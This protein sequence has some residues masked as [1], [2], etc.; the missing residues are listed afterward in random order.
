M[1]INDCQPLIDGMIEAVWIVDPLDLRIVA[2]NQAAEKLLGF[3]KEEQVGRPV[4]EL[5]VTPEDTCFWEDVAAGLSD[6]IL[7]ETLMR[8]ADGTVVQVERRASRVRTGQHSV[9]IVGIRDKTGERRIEDELETL[10]AELRATLESTADGIL[11]ATLDKAIRGYNHHFA[12]LWE[13]PDKL[14]TERDDAAVYDWM[15]RAVT[16][17]EGYQERL[18]VIARTPLLEATDIVVLRSGR[19]LERVTMPQY[20]RGRPIGRVFSFRDI[21]RRLA[22]ESRLQL[23]AKVFESSLDAIFISDSHYRIIAANPSCER[24]TGFARDEII[25]QNV[26]DL[27]YNSDSGDL[28]GA[29]EHTLGD[30]GVWEGEIWYRRKTG[31]ACPGLVSLVRV[32][33]EGHYIGFFKDLSE[34]M[35]AAKRIEELAYNDALTGLPNRVLLSERVQFAI[36]LASRAQRTFA[37]LFIDLDRFKQINDSLGHVF[38][39]RVLVEVAERIKKCLRVAD[40]AARLGGDEFVLLLHDVDSRGA[41]LT[42]QRLLDELARPLPLDGMSFTVTCSV[43]IAMY[44]EDGAT[45]DDLIKN[46]DTAMYRVKERGRSGFRF[47]Q[48]QMNIDLLSRMKLDHAMREALERDEFRLHYQPQVDL[49]SGRIVGAEALIRWTSAEMGAISPARFIPIAEESGLIIAIGNWVLRQAVR[50]AAQ[51]HEQGLD[52]VVAINVSALQFQQA[53][54]VTAVSDAIQEVGLPPDRLE[55]ELTESILIQDAQEALVRLQMLA[56]LGVR[57]SIDDFGTGYSS[58]TY[59]KR[60]PIQKLKID[61]SFVNGLPADES[62]GAIVTAIINLGRALKLDIIAEGVE[63]EGQRRFLAQAGCDHFQGYICSPAV[64]AG[65]FAALLAQTP[66]PAPLSVDPV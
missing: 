63:T 11:V 55:I 9:F 64:D 59:L 24:I 28:Y 57:L 23:A 38:G 17:P 10:I 58:L 19:V 20:A 13:L 26:R 60:F 5:A 36:S 22:D 52:L 27:M 31:A 48:R 32:V 42:A 30:T 35:A 56:A 16:D 21:T 40:T 47:Y 33:G 62:D 3:A 7:S 12:E 50:Q 6:H 34:R 8:R 46:A 65:Q 41:E 45:L 39:D 51:W 2:I 53:N 4:V 43:G 61:R 37:I 66:A 18:H 29:L 49:A 1:I 54:F 15:L 14:L 25:G 44:P